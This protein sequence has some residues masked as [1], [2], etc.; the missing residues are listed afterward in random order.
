[1]F[2]ILV[3]M[4]ECPILLPIAFVIGI[5]WCAILIVPCEIIG[6]LIWLNDRYGTPGHEPNLFPLIPFVILAGVY[7]RCRPH[8]YAIWVNVKG[9]TSGWVKLPNNGRDMS[10][11]E[12]SNASIVQS[13]GSRGTITKFRRYKQAR[14]FRDRLDEVF[15]HSHERTFQI[16]TI[17]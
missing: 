17:D 10:D 3:K 4:I 12:I 6:F 13:Y 7:Q 1:M 9:I 8:R 2:R 14:L 5:I 16:E 15:S 11:R